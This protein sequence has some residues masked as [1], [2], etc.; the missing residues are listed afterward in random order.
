MLPT[1]N[2]DKWLKEQNKKSTGATEVFLCVWHIHTD[3]HTPPQVSSWATQGAGPKLAGIVDKAY[4]T[5]TVPREKE[6]K[7]LIV[8]VCRWL[9]VCVSAAP[10][11]LLRC[12]Q[13]CLAVHSLSA[14]LWA[15]SSV[16]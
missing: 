12:L 16:S 5:P 11:A 14:C 8:C 4:R 2:W 10:K 7:E 9:Y 1:E 15:Y 3:T 6:Y 13:Y